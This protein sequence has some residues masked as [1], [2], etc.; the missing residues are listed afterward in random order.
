MQEVSPALIEYKVECDEYWM[1]RSVMVT[2]ETEGKTNRLQLT[3]DSDQNWLCNQSILYFASGLSDVDLAFSP[4]T[5]TLPIRKLN[6]RVG[7]KR[8]V[9]A[10]WVLPEDLRLARVSQS[11]SRIDDRHYGYEYPSANF[12]VVLEVDELGLIVRYGDLW[13]RL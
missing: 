1:T 10:V 5:N 9:E 4:S 3:V 11:Y 13:R 12:K 7:E 2:Q 6:L 8:T